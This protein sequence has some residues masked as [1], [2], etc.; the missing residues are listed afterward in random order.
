MNTNAQTHNHP[1]FTTAVALLLSLAGF[2]P[3]VR[4]DAIR[5]DGIWHENVL[6]VT[7]ERM[8]YVLVPDDGS[9]LNVRPETLEESDL[10]LIPESPERDALRSTWK[11]ARKQMDLEPPPPR[12]AES[13]S[14]ARTT[15]V[16]R[17]LPL[18]H[19]DG[20]DE[21]TR[22]SP[23]EPA[24]P[25]TPAVVVDPS[26]RTAGMV[27]HIRLKNVPLGEALK[28]ILRPLGLDYVNMGS[29]IFISTPER[30][31]REPRAPVET[32]TYPLD[33]GKGGSL[34][35]IVVRNPGL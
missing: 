11:A 32:R 21:T 10:R 34:P 25:D 35:K 20:Q 18:Q 6:V 8:H 30:L 7:G 23:P 5:I 29:Y 28:V 19:A 24:A 16:A 9:I 3:A 27:R 26:G 17:P 2:G 4:A 1:L 13:T 14:T 12:D 22:K 15:D 31:R 33:S